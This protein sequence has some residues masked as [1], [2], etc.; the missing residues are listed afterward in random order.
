MDIL[1]LLIILLS[2]IKII[3]AFEIKNMFI[4][5]KREILFLFIS[6]IKC[7]TSTRVS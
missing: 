5:R 6:T 7:I 4:Y 2:Q 1:L 3:N